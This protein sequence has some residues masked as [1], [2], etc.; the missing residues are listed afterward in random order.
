MDG[1][2]FF[3][4]LYSEFYVPFPC[5]AV[6][7]EHGEGFAT[8][9][10]DDGTEALVILT[11]DDLLERFLTRAG[12]KPFAAKLTYPELL[13][14]MLRRLPPTITH[15]TFDP[16]PTF[17]RRYPIDAVRASLDVPPMKKAG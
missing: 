13:A 9:P 6:A 10:A 14:K 16:S 3:D 17:H 15:V 8:E 11:D 5:Y 12:G 1:E 4:R 7:L 2:E